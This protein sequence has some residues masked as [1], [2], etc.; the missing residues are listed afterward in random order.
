MEYKS[1]NPFNSGNLSFSQLNS[2]VSMKGEI[3][4]K[5]FIEKLQ[6]KFGKVSTLL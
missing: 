3:I 4:K 1:E 5:L 2:L 6:E